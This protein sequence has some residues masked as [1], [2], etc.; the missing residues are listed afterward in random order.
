MTAYLREHP[1]RTLPQ[2]RSPRR[3]RLTGAIVVHTAENTPD[4]VAF[5][6][7]AEAVASYISRRDSYGSYHDLVDSD[8][9]VHLVD[10]DDEA[11]H[12]GTGGNRF[13]LGLS[14]ATRADV[15]PLAPA[16]WR[17]GAVEQAAQAA[18]RMARH[19]YAKRGIV[20][21]AKRIT[22]GQYRA[23]HAGFVSHGE[24]DPGRRTDP[25]AEFPWSTFLTRYAELTRDLG[26]AQPLPHRPQKDFTMDDEARARF[27]SIDQRLKAIESNSAKAKQYATEAVA[28]L[29]GS[30]KRAPMFWRRIKG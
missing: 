19:V 16:A 13:S 11:F 27:D 9:T 14:V 30:A 18:A 28:I 23:G 6:G 8:S 7:G 5:D 1:N 10:Y 20:V 4:F 26:N 21:P 12:D 15:W 29:I 25:G 22:A 3:A 2:Y 24:L 17:A